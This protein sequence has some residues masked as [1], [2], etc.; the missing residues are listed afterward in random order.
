MLAMTCVALSLEADRKAAAANI[1]WG[2]AFLCA[3]VLIIAYNIQR[4]IPTGH[5]HRWDDTRHNAYGIVIEQ[6]CRC[7]EYR[8]HYFYDLGSRDE[9]RWLP[10][11]MP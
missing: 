10:G 3:F 11:R 8:H 2:A 9:I 5:L 1:A 6:R 7:G 4:R